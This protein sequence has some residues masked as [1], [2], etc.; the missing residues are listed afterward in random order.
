M[1]NDSSGLTAAQRPPLTAELTGAEL[2][3]WYFLR[4]ELA[5]FARRLGV[6]AAGGKQDLT[7]RLAAALDGTPVP[8]PT[9][10]AIGGADQ[11]EGELTPDT[12]I[13]EGQRCSQHLRAFFAAAIGKQFRF[14][15]AMRSFISGHHPGA[16]LA[17]AL[18][19]WHRSRTRSLGRIDPQFE[20]NRFT[21]QWY[22][23]HPRGSREDLRAAWVAYRSAPAD[24]RGR[25]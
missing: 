3:R 9:K 19:H 21:R 6:S 20:L 23:D 13:P 2:R 24:Q 8:S 15:A 22:L 12:V 4:D 18:D 10:R 25:A 14:D 7:D 5:A 17:D 1:D 11:L 16:T